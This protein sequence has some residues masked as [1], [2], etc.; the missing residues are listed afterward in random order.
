[1]LRAGVVGQEVLQPRA[2]DVQA[3]QHGGQGVA[4]ADAGFADIGGVAG[5]ADL[6]LARLERQ[7]AVDQAQGGSSE[8]SGC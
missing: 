8:R 2:V 5:V 6:H 4:G 3:L 7:D 1:M